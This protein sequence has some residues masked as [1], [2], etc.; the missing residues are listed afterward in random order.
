MISKKNA[1]YFIKRVSKDI[2]TLED[3]RIIDKE[4]KEWLKTAEPSEVA[5]YRDSGAGEMLHLCC[6]PW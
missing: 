1:E 5:K 6:N 2:K 4:V 3:A